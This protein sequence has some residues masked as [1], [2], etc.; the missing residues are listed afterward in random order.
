MLIEISFIQ[1]FILFLGHPVLSLRVLLFSLL[2]GAGIGSVWSGRFS[3]NKIN[4]SIALTSLCIVGMVLGYTFLLPM[5][6]N[7]L[8]G[9]NLTTRLLTTIIIL[10]P[11]GFLMGIPFPLGI[12]WLKER[13]LRNHIPWMW[14]INGA[15]SVLGSVMTIVV[16]ISFGFAEA[17]LVSA[18]CYLIIFL[19]FLM[20]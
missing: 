7:Q 18:G 20:P 16:A 5:L 13:N 17:L 3:P 11:L 10:I 15:S 6:F 19:I 1:K 12:R 14:G 9:V 4:K 8:L 2:G